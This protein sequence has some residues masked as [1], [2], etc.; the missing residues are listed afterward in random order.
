MLGKVFPRIKEKT[1]NIERLDGARK[2][3]V[4]ETYKSI[5]LKKL[6]K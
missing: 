5:K 6:Y 3:K 2:Q 4:N 1:L